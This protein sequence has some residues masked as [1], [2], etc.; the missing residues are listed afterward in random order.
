MAQHITKD[1]Q[2]QKERY[3]RSRRDARRYTVAKLVLVRLTSE[4]ATGASRKLLP[5]YKG[6]FRI[7]TVLPNDLYEVEDVREGGEAV[8]GGCRGRSD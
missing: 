4:P 8:P 2:A 5:K 3:D 7:R 1:Q 6:P